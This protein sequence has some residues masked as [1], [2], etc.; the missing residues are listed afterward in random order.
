MRNAKRKGAAG[1]VLKFDLRKLRE[2]K[3]TLNLARLLHQQLCWDMFSTGAKPPY[4]PNSGCYVAG[5]G[6]SFHYVLPLNSEP[7]QKPIPTRT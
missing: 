4:A 7:T 2:E 5:F 1:R 3:R 6:I